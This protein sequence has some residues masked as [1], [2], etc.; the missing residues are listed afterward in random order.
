[1]LDRFMYRFE[2][3]S[4]LVLRIVVGLIFIAH[5]AQKL[6]GAFGG[7]GLSG[8]AQFFEQIGIVPG[9]FWAWVVG[10]V[11]FVGGLALLI[12][13]LTRYAA[14]LLAINMLIAILIVHLPNGFFLPNGYE[15]ALALL[16]ANLTL[17]IGGAGELAFDR[18]LYRWSGQERTGRERPGM[19]H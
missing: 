12:G 7:S 19:A 9:A 5:G 13:L 18:Y 10:S 11:E 15:Y 3:Y 1:M 6:F 2:P 17:L 14:A 16:A 8:T 4:H